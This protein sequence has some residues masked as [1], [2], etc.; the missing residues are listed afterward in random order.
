MKT[1]EDKEGKN[2]SNWESWEWFYQRWQLSLILK[3]ESGVF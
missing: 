1:D 2:F 3:D